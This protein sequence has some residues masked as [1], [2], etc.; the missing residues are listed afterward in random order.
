[1]QHIQAPEEAGHLS[2]EVEQI[3]GSP[4]LCVSEVGPVIGA[5]VGPGLLGVGGMPPRPA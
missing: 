2:Q 3:M 4:P 1:M 5:H